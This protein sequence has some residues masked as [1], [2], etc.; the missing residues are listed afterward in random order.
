MFVMVF[1]I[2][3]LSA[4][5]PSTSALG[6]LT[7]SPSPSA[8]F[9]SARASLVFDTGTFDVLV[10]SL[11]LLVPDPSTSPRASLV[12]D[13][14]M[15]FVSLGL[16]T[17]DPSTSPRLPLPGTSLV[18]D[19]GMIDFLVDLLVLSVL[20]PSTSGPLALFLVS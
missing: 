16:L 6:P 15:F 1:G 13:T 9:A 18:F 7:P 11:A 19:T 2:L 20:D 5:D 3:G 10:D 8:P 17:P 14:G 12:F 4:S